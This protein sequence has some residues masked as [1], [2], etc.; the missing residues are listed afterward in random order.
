MA[1]ALTPHVCTVDGQTRCEG[2]DCGDGQDRDVGVCDKSGCDWNPYRVGDHSF[3]GPGANYT[4]DSSR[5]F[6]VVTQFITSDG[7]DSGDLVSIRRSYIQD[8]KRINTTAVKI[9]GS[10]EFDSITDDFCSA[11]AAWMN[12]TDSFGQRGGLKRLGEQSDSG[13]VLVMSLWDDGAAR[14]LWLDSD[15]PIGAD[16]SS[17]GTARGPCDTSSGVPADV[18]AKYPDATAIYSNIRYGELG[19]TTGPTPPTPPTP[20]PPAPGAGC[21]GCGYA[22]GG[23][24]ANCGRCN[25]KPGC[26][27]KDTCLTNCNGGGN[28]M[29]CG[30][31]SPTPP[32]PP[33]PPSPPTPPAPPACPGGSL[34]ACIGLCPSSPPAAYKACVEDCTKRCA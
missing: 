22:C 8:G 5:V 20:P 34:S 6:T 16:P 21:N 19:S 28:A 24:C 23:N 14:M 1:T 27:S 13:M 26:M 17:P 9:P 7:T 33:T 10:S 2:K 4:V 3:Y 11:R 25:T 18:R 15:Y 31:S 32:T 12:D 29:W 30:G